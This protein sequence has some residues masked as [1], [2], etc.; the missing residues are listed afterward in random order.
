LGTLEINTA[1]FEKRMDDETRADALYT[2]NLFNERAA[3]LN[4]SRWLASMRAGKG[5]Y[6]I[7]WKEGEGTKVTH[8]MPDREE[9]KAYV[10]TFRLFL[11]KS[12]SFSFWRLRSLYPRLDAVSEELRS[13]ALGLIERVNAYLDAMSCIVMTNEEVTRRHL[14]DV[15]LHGGL[16]HSN[17]RTNKEIL[18]YWRSRPDLEVVIDSG[19]AEIVLTLTNGIFMMRRL[20]LRALEEL[21]RQEV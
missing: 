15:V 3:E 1:F 20:N 18:D 6:N 21:A 13:E 8:D 7:S 5:S 10:L 14:L 2:L 16:A 17:N 11:Q 9:L 4:E 12:E 19:F